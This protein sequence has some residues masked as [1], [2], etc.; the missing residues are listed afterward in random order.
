MNPNESEHICN[1]E[2]FAG[3]DACGKYF[4][5]NKEKFV[6]IQSTHLCSKCVLKELDNVN[7]ST[8]EI[9]FD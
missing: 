3:C 1:D 2:C 4:C 5:K 6:C 8:V 7:L 9:D